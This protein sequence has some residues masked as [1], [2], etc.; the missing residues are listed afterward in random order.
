M[1]NS[2]SPRPSSSREETVIN[3]LQDG[4]DR[5]IGQSKRS[6]GE[7]KEEPGQEGNENVDQEFPWTKALRIAH[8]TQSQTNLHTIS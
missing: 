4:D 6:R 7:E 3:E 5:S 2:S 8:V 1:F